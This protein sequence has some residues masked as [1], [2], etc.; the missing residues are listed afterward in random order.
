[1]SGASAAED[2]ALAV[3]PYRRRWGRRTKRGRHIM[4]NVVRN[5]GA[6]ITTGLHGVRSVEQLA[7]LQNGVVAQL[8]AGLISAADALAALQSLTCRWAMEALGEACR[9]ARPAS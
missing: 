7:E 3:L 8:S 2:A 6:C 4:G 9:P 5:D 1:M